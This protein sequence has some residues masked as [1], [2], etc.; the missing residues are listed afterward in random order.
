MC[1]LSCLIIIL[2][3]SIK[4]KGITF[5]LIFVANDK[6]IAYFLGQTSIYLVVLHFSFY[7][8]ELN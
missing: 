7:E 2:L 8:F 1:L 5:E 3:K 6:F 4:T